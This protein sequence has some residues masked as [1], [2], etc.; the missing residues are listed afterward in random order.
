[1]GYTNAGKSTLL[2]R[3]TDSDVY[4]HDQLFATLDSVARRVEEPDGQPYLLVDTVGF[5]RKL[6]HTLVNAFHATLEEAVRADVLGIVSDGSAPDMMQQHDTV[7]AVLKEL[8]ADHQV[9]V[10]VINKSDLLPPDFVQPALPGAVCISARR[11]DGMD[12]LRSAIRQALG[13][14]R[15]EMT[16]SVPYSDYAAV[17]KIREA[18]QVLEEKHTDTGTSL[19]VSLLPQ[20]RDRLISMLGTKYIVM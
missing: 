10:E 17:S 2:N 3:M 15:T 16:F 7:E 19:K 9:R 14:G 12:Q 20:D 6:P 5:I 8:G 11:G 13:A 1:M 4:V 18:A